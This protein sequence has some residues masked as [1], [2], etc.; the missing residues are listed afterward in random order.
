MTGHQQTISMKRLPWII[1]LMVFLCV[2]P[3][4]VA[5]QAAIAITDSLEVQEI[6]QGVWVHTTWKAV[7]GWGRIR[8]NGLLIV[9]DSTGFLVDTAWGHEPTRALLA[10]VDTHLQIRIEQAVLT[11]AHADRMGGIA[12]L[13]ERDIPT[14]ATTRTRAL[15]QAQGWPLPDETF[16]KAHR[17]SVGERAIE[18]FYPGAAH[19]VDNAVVWLPDARLLFGGCMIKGA[20]S[21]SLG[22]LADADVKAWPATLDALIARYPKPSVVIP[23]HS[24]PGDHTLLSRTARLLEQHANGN[25]DKP[26]Q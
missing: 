3:R 21:K 25:E 24:P 13:R 12:V 2:P 10:W 17:V 26:D 6:Q 18:L 7:E 20:H 1:P 22:N 4:G 5:Q 9:A 16:E 14:V 8:S 19:T 11:H 23:S 15:A